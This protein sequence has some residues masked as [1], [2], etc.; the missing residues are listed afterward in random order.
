MLI[1]EQAPGSEIRCFLDPRFLKRQCGPRTEA[2]GRVRVR[3][4]E[5]LAVCTERRSV[6]AGGCVR[7]PQAGVRRCEVYTLFEIFEEIVERIALVGN[8]I[9][10]S[11][12]GVLRTFIKL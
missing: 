2:V 6:E 8:H 5:R 9:R 7:G 10:P 1:A 4:L 12:I 11:L 3:D